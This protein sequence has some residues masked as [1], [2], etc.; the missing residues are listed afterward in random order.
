MAVCPAEIEPGA[1]T[2]VV[3]SCGVAEHP[4]AFTHWRMPC[5][6]ESTSFGFLF[7]VPLKKAI[8][9]LTRVL[10][11]KSKFQREPA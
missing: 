8:G 2:N 5:I 4:S 11:P 1:P 10:L 3:P 7:G 9:S 6:T